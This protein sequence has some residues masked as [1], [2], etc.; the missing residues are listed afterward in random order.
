MGKYERQRKFSRPMCVQFANEAYKE[1][2]MI[3][4][5]VPQGQMSPITVSQH[6]PYEL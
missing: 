1:I 5:K 6:L 4:I 2:L 3:H